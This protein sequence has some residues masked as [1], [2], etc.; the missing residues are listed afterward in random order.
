MKVVIQRV[1]Q[2]SVSV[3]GKVVG[4]IQKGALILY[5]SHKNDTK[6]QILWLVSKIK[7]LRMFADKEGKM[8]QSLLDVKGDLLIVSQ[9]TLYG[10]CR[11][12]RRPSFID[13]M[14]PEKAEEF[15]EFFIQECKKEISN[16]QTGKFG[17]LMDVSLVNSGPVTFI[18]DTK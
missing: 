15:Y 14:K 12:G 5:A 2:A 10:D 9:F 11:K 4:Q 18:I 16:V 8:N 13:A 1:K 7:N 17:A 3:D 6:D